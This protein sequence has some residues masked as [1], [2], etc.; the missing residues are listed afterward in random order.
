[1]EAAAEEEETEEPTDLVELEID[2]KLYEV[3]QDMKD[4]F[5]RNSDYTQKTQEVSTLKKQAEARLAAA[6]SEAAKYEFLASVQDE[7]AQVQSID[8]QIPQYKQYLRDNIDSLSS[9]DIEKIRFQIEELQS[10]RQTISEAVNKKTTD[11]QQAREQSFKELTDK[12]TEVLRSAIPN[13]NTVEKDVGEFVRSL[14]FTEQ[15]LQITSTD[16][17]QMQLAHDAW[18]YRQLKEGKAAAVK[19]VQAAPT[20]K[21]KRSAPRS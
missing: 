5:M 2:G 14:G 20:I 13:W 21:A 9:S 18:R 11:F 6:E 12:S 15:Q 1:M 4:A 7:V 19:K 8:A 3:P 16:P 10:Q 17:T